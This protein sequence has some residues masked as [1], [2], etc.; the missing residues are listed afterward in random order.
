[1]NTI[2][3][4]S[5]EK[6][7][8]ETLRPL[9]EALERACAAVG[10]DFYL[11]GAVARDI[12]MTGV[13]DLEP[14]RATRDVDLAVL[15][16]TEAEYTR[17]KEALLGE[18]TFSESPRNPLTLFFEGKITVDLMPF[19]GVEV[20]DGQVHLHRGQGVARF[21]VNGFA[22]VNEQATAWVAVDDTLRFRVCTLPGILVLKWIA[23]DDRPEHRLKDLEDI[24]FILKNYDQI[25]GDALFTDHFDL[26]EDSDSLEA[27]AARIAGRD[28][29][30]LL[31][32]S[33]ALRT[34]VAAILDRAMA[35]GETGVVVRQMQ[36]A[37]FSHRPADVVLGLLEHFRQGLDDPLTT[38]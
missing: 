9:F 6:L 8:H 24:A 25:A 35:E 36:R 29:R 18:G 3:Q 12:W 4:V 31:S 27:T 38:A 32:D 30:P 11:V 13:H 5:L 37:Q 15:V 28:V 14:S 2:Y 7:R 19:G 21:A 22:E 17:L 10:L 26:L 1:M 23:F 16:P 20:A 33:E 34:R